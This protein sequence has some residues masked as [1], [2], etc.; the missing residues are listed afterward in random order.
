MTCESIL[1]SYNRFKA[2]LLWALE[3][4]FVVLMKCLLSPHS[5]MSQTYRCWPRV[6]IVDVCVLSKQVSLGLGGLKPLSS[7]TEM[8]TKV[9]SCKK[10]KKSQVK[11]KKNIILIWYQIHNYFEQRSYQEF[12]FLSDCTII[13]Y[14]L[15]VHVIQ[16]F[17]LLNL[18]NL[19]RSFNVYMYIV[20][21]I[22]LQLHSCV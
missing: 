7:H 21:P 17:Y 3:H 10:K 4:Y 16:V 8:T 15:Y 6:K 13:F 22:S 9:T 2:V 20:L 5:V 11:K 14:S 12:F 1:Q 18:N 19:H